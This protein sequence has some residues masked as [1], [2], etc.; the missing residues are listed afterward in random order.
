MH[1][2]TMPAMDCAVAS[3]GVG[4]SALAAP[5]ALMGEAAVLIWN[6]VVEEG[7]EQFYQW[8]DREHIPERLTLPG[9]RRGRRFV[10]PGHSP[11]WLTIYE[12]AD[13]GVVTS[14][15]YLERLNAPT[16]ATV[17]TL[18]YFRNTSRAVCSLVYSEGAST[19]GHML[20]L[21]LGV[22]AENADL[23]CTAIRT[24]LFPSAMNLTGIVACH[25]FASDQVAS[26]VN[27]TES[28][29]RTF[30]VP[31]WVILCEATSTVAAERAREVVDGSEFRR[32]DIAVRD[33]A[34]IY[35]LE[36]CRLSPR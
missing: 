10:S 12:A 27:T 23:M 21:R 36:I 25:L 7:R 5:S 17:S 31:S 16:P 22:P 14:P 18:R 29:T 15:E 11:E 26:H 8:H 35:G 9:F 1:T 20:A 2:G 30:D 3:P 6:D 4:S 33:D 34:A 19:G 13:L 28:S 24:D 32:L